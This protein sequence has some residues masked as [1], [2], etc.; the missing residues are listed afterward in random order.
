MS[1]QDAYKGEDICKTLYIYLRGCLGQTT[2]GHSVELEQNK[3]Q[4]N[5]VLL[6]AFLRLWSNEGF[7]NRNCFNWTV[8]LNKNSTENCERV[9]I[10]TKICSACRLPNKFA[11]LMLALSKHL[12]PGCLD[13]HLTL[14][15]SCYFGR[16]VH[17]HQSRA[18]RSQLLEK[19][20]AALAIYPRFW[21][22]SGSTFLDSTHSTRIISGGPQLVADLFKIGEFAFIKCSKQD[23]KIV[24]ELQDSAN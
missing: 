3:N 4:L 8:D 18:S 1:L 23:F 21:W 9:K 15:A 10:A 12:R 20:C 2:V 13:P 7:N 19:I 11:K 5:F 14:F 22:E 24:F 17:H 6:C 16:K